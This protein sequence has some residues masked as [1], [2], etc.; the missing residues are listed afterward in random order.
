MSAPKAPLLKNVAMTGAFIPL[1]AEGEG[2]VDVEIG[3]PPSN[4][5]TV[6]LRAKDSADS[7]TMIAGEYHFFKSVDLSKFE[8]DGT[9]PDVICIYGQGA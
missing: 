7:I 4:G 6:T 2:A 8:A 3:A 5:N 1:G 9:A